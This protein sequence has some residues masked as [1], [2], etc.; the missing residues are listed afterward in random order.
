VEQEKERQKKVFYVKNTSHFQEKELKQMEQNK[1]LSLKMKKRN[2]RRKIALLVK[3][4]K[5]RL[6]RRTTTTSQGIHT[7]SLGS[8]ML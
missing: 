5:L 4:E 1:I 3:L 7:I 6:A 2:Y 8:Y